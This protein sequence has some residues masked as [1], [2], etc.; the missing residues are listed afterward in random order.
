MTAFHAARR[1]PALT[2][3]ALACALFAQSFALS[4]AHAQGAAPILP[5]V[6]IT[7]SRFDNAP[8]LQPIGATVITA[9]AIRQSGV[10]D[11]NA[12]IRKLGGVYGRQALDGSPD[13]ALDLRGFGATSLQNLVVMVDGVRISENDL[14]S[15][16]LSTIPVDLVER[17]EIV[18][19]GSSV[20]YG[21][22]ATG[23]V[24]QIVTRRARKSAMR[25]TV[26]AE[27][28]QFGHRDIRAS[29]S[30]SWERLTVDAA[31]N[32]QKTDNWRRHSAFDLDTANVGAQWTY[33]A[34]RVG[35]RAERSQSEAE[36][37]G[38][39]TLAEFQANARQTKTPRDFGTL[40]ANRTTAF[41]EH[42]AGAFDLAAEL[43]RR[44]KTLRSDYYYPD[45]SRT[46]FDSRNEQFSPRLRHLSQW[47][48]ALNELVAGIDLARWE[49][50]VTSSFGDGMARQKSKAIYVRD[51]IKLDD[52]RIAAGARREL[53]EKD[54]AEY[55]KQGENAWELQGSV[56]L[57]PRL[58]AHAKLG[59][60]YRVPN[61]DENGY[62][63]SL[64]LLRIQTSRD[65]EAGISMGDSARR[66]S[67]RAF[68]H[69]LTN[70]IFFDPTV[71]G[72]WG[73]NV[74]LD[75]TERKGLEVEAEAQLG[76]AWRVSGQ[77][78]HVKAG[79]RAGPNDGREMV[80]VP[81]NALT[82]RLSWNP[83]SGHSADLGVQWV[84]S[85]R[86]G[87]DFANSCRS[88]VPSYH[89]VDGRYARKLG[90][91]EFA[92][93]GLNLGDE[94]YFSN[95]FGCES[96]IY[97]SSGRQLKASVRYDF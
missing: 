17:I 63:M 51:E 29:A 31:V 57:A 83:G 44:D 36:L 48:G 94:R 3:F 47:G 53:F 28:G 59:R 45:L 2:P 74:N 89:T 37:P 88:R 54:G 96:G 43:S 5:E 7:G 4:S 79:F 90:A 10:N 69:A 52:V 67:A 91:W 12:A 85:Q 49:R 80:L 22:G 75:P 39:L 15:T 66:L 25:G 42:R 62:R 70:E 33:G 84:S 30:R 58:T 50:T 86:Y 46:F 81:K 19:G 82:T 32:K 64:D 77:Y 56:E 38:S 40:R 35:L 68:R 95:A 60:S 16:V 65:L 97:P 41:V 92:V 6:T 61:A 87:N 1:S 11:L 18:R 24:I 13:W 20:L 8:A 34:G 26:S 73:A 76:A 78:Q 71:N 72:G 9:D 27:A 55:R 93:A 14:G 23:G 21:E